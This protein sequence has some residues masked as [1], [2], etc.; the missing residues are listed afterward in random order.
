MQGH[1]LV[2]QLDYPQSASVKNILCNVWT[3]IEKVYIQYFWG[4]VTI[5]TI[6]SIATEI[7]AWGG[8]KMLSIKRSRRDMEIQ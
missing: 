7:S 6:Q 2:S 5:K 3:V 8:T 4:P 1:C